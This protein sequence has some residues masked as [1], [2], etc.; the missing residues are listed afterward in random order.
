MNSIAR[1]LSILTF[2]AVLAGAL[3]ASAADPDARHQDA[4]EQIA[5]AG[6]AA[7]LARACGVDPRPIT[8]AV[9]DVFG[10][11]GYTGA[12]RAEALSRYRANEARMTASLPAAPDSSACSDP[13][14]LL[15]DPIRG[16]GA[17]GP[18]GQ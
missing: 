7:G 6:S 10:R 1:S 18:Q 9:N 4:T 5:L 17:I 15:R 2:L 13:R 3:P 16:L 11:L 12:E 14:G 8:A